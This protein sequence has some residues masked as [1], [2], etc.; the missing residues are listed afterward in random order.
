MIIDT[1][2]NV[3]DKVWGVQCD[4]S[5]RDVEC[6][7]CHGEGGACIPGTGVFVRCQDC[8]G[9]S[10]LEREVHE[11][12]ATERVIDSIDV[13]VKCDKVNIQYGFLIY[14][15]HYTFRAVAEDRDGAMAEATGGGGRIRG[16]QGVM[17][18]VRL[19]LPRGRLPGGL[20][21]EAGRHRSTDPEGQGE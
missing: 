16:V 6:P 1:R 3:G 5:T 12:S 7:A 14:I 15:Y 11:Y 21:P 20:P 10:T 2:W 4:W 8:K 19:L 17:L 18:H 9:K 13:K